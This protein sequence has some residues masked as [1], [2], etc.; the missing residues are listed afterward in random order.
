VGV[1]AMARGSEGE[2]VGGMGAPEL[3]PVP[4]GLVGY[5]VLVFEV[6]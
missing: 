5:I 2:G 6:L 3:V 1:N 4:T